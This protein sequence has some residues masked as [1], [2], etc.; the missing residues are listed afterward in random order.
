MTWAEAP[1]R[2]TT[3]CVHTVGFDQVVIAIALKFLLVPRIFAVVLA[4]IL[5]IGATSAQDAAPLSLVEATNAAPCTSPA[6]EASASSVRS[7][8]AARP[9][10]RHRATHIHN[11]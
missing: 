11:T 6:I 5:S 10:A 9:I 2:V 4:A 1:Q 7:S 8:N 3:S